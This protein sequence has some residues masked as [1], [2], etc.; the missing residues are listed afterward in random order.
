[1]RPMD[2]PI[3]DPKMDISIP[4]KIITFSESSQMRLLDKGTKYSSG[5]K[6]ENN[7]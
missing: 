7:S 1:M 5:S 3:Y 2:R 6:D 4:P